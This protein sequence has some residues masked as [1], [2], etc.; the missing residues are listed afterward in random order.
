MV[1]CSEPSAQVLIFPLALASSVILN[2][3]LGLVLQFPF[4]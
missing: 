3:L 1:E 2:D 4:L